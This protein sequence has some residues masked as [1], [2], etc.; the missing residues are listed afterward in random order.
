VVL[1]NLHPPPTI[2]DNI[3]VPPYQQKGGAATL[4]P[5]AAAVI[6]VI[7][8]PISLYCKHCSVV[9]KA[10]H[11]LSF[12]GGRHPPP[13]GPSPGMIFIIV[14]IIISLPPIIVAMFH[15]I[16]LKPPLASGK[17]SL[18]SRASARQSLRP[19]G[20]CP[21]RIGWYFYV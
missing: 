10:I 14:S 19:H 11:V 7:L 1:T 18:L 15:F 9:A 17:Y 21:S 4:R 16:L 8:H 13:T 5:A 6:D 20:G 12:R 2:D 3:I